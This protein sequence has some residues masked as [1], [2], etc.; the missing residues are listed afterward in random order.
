MPFNKESP[1]LKLLYCTSSFLLSR[2]FID[3]AIEQVIAS[4][5]TFAVIAT[6]DVIQVKYKKKMLVLQEMI[7]K[8]LLFKDFSSSISFSDPNA[9]SKAFSLTDFQSKA[10]NR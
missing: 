5:I 7:E 3:L 9:S 6:A 10:S 2:S 1:T 4:A 8:S